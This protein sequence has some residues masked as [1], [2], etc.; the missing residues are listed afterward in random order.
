MLDVR[1]VTKRFGGLVAVSDVTLS[2]PEGSI[3]G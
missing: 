1:S 2:V 3:T